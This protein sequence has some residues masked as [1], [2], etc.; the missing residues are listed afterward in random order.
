MK[1]LIFLICLVCQ[2]A[3][4]NSIDVCFTPG[5][6]CA[7][8]II[9]AIN[10]SKKQVLVQAYSFTNISIAQALEAADF[11]GVDVEILLD[12]SQL[13]AKNSVFKF[14]HWNKI[15]VKI[16]YIP[17]IAHNKVMVIDDAIVITG[18][19]N[20]TTSAEKRNAEN[21]LIIQDKDLAKKYKINWIKRKRISK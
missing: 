4:A 3:S 9:N 17:A 5:E 12:K 19:Y 21:L 15:P 18:S 6:N 14:L 11:R 20:F 7:Q 13:T 16:D 8:Q 2:A 10:Q 1:K